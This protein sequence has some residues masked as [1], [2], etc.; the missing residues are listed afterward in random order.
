M[1]HAFAIERPDVVVADFEGDHYD[2]WTVEGDA[3]GTGPTRAELRGQGPPSGWLGRGFADSFVKGN[4]GT[5]TLRSAPFRIERHYLNFLIGGGKDVERLGLRLKVDGQTVLTATG[6]NDATGKM[7]RLDWHAWDVSAWDGKEATLELFDAST[8]NAILLDQIVQSDADFT[9]M[10]ASRDLRVEH[11]WLRI[12]V[13]NGARHTL[14][15]LSR[16]GELLR[17][18]EVELA[19]G[20]KPDFWV[21]ENVAP[22]RGQTLRLERDWQP[23]R[24]DGLAAVEQVDA[25]PEPGLYREKYRPQFHY[26]SRRGRQLDPVGLVY[27]NGEFHIFCEHFSYGLKRTAIRSWGHAVSKDL[28]HWTE[29]PDAV[30]TDRYGTVYSGSAVADVND[31]AGLATGPDKVIACFYTSASGMN[32]AS[33]G[34]LTSQSMCYSPDNGKTWIK[35]PK[36]PVVP[37]VYGGNRDPKV[38]WHEPSKSWIMALFLKPGVYTL[39]RS[40][41]LTEWTRLSDISLPGVIENPDLFQL[42]VDGDPQETRWVF[43]ANGNYYVGQFDGKAFIP[44]GPVWSTP[45]EGVYAQQTF[46]NFSGRHVQLG[47]LQGGKFPDMP[48]T[49]QMTVP[50]EITLARGPSGPEVRIQPVP[51]LELLRG[52]THVWAAG[53]AAP[54]SNFLEGFTAELLDLELTL[55]PGEAKKIVLTVHGQPITYDAAAHTLS[56]FGR[57]APYPAGQPLSLR[58]LVDRASIEIFGAAGRTLLAAPYLIDPSQIGLSLQADHKINVREAK[59]WSLAS[60]WPQP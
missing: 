14:M 32:P 24:G 47:Y 49:Q 5:G 20:A 34:Q 27:A 43:C 39:L 4:E 26:T 15:R 16:E 51:E 48:F 8:N 57:T 3:F 6:P 25:W 50:R 60:I 42:P 36:N 19:D 7:Q 18:F 21:Y 35:H 59:A 41:N 52:P 33:Y 31:T 17:E 46:S 56:A 44:E 53:G 28:L 29:L 40:P 38:I 10:R 13:K 55:D 23:P 30:Y 11:D 2:G 37:N 22:F 54:G 9:R 12:P 58:V 45:W 1:A